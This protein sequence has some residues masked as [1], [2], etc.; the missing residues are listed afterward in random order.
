MGTESVE[1][2]KDVLTTFDESE[3]AILKGLFESEGIPCRVESSRVSQIPVSVGELGELRVLVRLRDYDRA[4]R[5]LESTR[6][7][8]P[9]E[10]EEL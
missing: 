9:G 1:R 8:S 10:E 5:I 6:L 2:W 4:A 3:A 7:V